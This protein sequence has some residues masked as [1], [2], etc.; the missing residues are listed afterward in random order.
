LPK[1]NQRRVTAVSGHIDGLRWHGGH[2]GICK[3]GCRLGRSQTRARYDP[4]RSSPIHASGTHRCP[5]HA[6]W[7][8]VSRRIGRGIGHGGS[9]REVRRTISADGLPI[10]GRRNHP[11]GIHRGRWRTH[12]RSAVD[13]RTGA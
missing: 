2:R 8:G 6:H 13:P 1:A 10:H 11:L 3:R 12:K 7:I 5:S 4:C 9:S